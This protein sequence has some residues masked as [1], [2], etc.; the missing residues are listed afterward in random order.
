MNFKKQTSILA[1]LIVMG[2]AVS[3]ASAH[4]CFKEPFQNYYKFKSV[5]C[6]TCHPDSKKETHNRF[7]IVYVKALEGKN[8]TKMFRE[9]EAKGNQAA[10]AKVE[11]EMVAEFMKIV[12]TVEDE[13]M[14]FKAL[15]ASGLINGT[16][17]DKKE[18]GREGAAISLEEYE[19]ELKAAAEAAAKKKAEEAKKKGKGDHGGEHDHEK[20]EH[21]DG[22]EHKTSVNTQ[23]F[24]EAL[25]EVAK[26][27]DDPAMAEAL[28]FMAA[29]A[30]NM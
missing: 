27:D 9:A 24:L 6:K 25:R 17:L 21:K 12:P 18:D 29:L 16:R 22:K 30:V 8:L 13:A 14:T 10:L 7:G 15:L 2:F 4:D 23:F 3:A 28:S 1:V 11:K 19:K 26:T 5:S 20:G